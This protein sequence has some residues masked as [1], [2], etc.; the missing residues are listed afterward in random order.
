MGNSMESPRKTKNRTT[1]YDPA[2]PAMLLGIYLKKMKLC[3]ERCMHSSVQF[4]VALFIK[5]RYGSNCPT[6]DEW[7]KKM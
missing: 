2:I 4:I 3:F 7:I 1:I 5:P 6:I